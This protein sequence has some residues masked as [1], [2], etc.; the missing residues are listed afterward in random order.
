MKES[1]GSRVR[2]RNFVGKAKKI[3]QRLAKI[4]GRQNPNRFKLDGVGPVDNRPS[5]PP[6]KKVTHDM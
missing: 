1:W 4:C 3:F 6:K 5:R 2:R